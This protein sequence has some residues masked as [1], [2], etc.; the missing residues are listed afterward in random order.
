MKVSEV[1]TTD[2]KIADPNRTIQDAAKLMDKNDCG[3]LPVGE[4]DRLV[5]MITDRDIVIRAV[6][7]GLPASTPIRDVMTKEMKY[8][9]ENDDIEDVARN[10]G[11]VQMRRLPVLNAEKRIVGIVSIGDLARS[12]EECA[13]NALADIAQPGNGKAAA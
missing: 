9:H 13:G 4:A 5:G 11:E 3:S 1:M 10:M 7:A 8:C 12:D 6:A 2:V